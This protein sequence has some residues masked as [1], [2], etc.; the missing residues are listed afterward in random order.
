[1]AA[2]PVPT[3]AEIMRAFM[4]WWKNEKSTFNYG[5]YSRVAA[6]EAFAAGVAHVLELDGGWRKTEWP[7]C[8]PE[9]GQ[10]GTVVYGI[11][12]PIHQKDA[13]AALDR[14]PVMA[15]QSDRPGS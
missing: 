9:C 4:R 14:Q 12:C 15:A 8:C 10:K 5:A 1:M 2:Y 7:E 13:L 11:L 6:Q 3:D